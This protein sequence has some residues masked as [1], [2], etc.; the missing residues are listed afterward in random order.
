MN[1]Y[2][3]AWTIPDFA[4]IVETLPEMSPDEERSSHCEHNLAITTFLPYNCYALGFFYWSIL[5]PPTTTDCCVK[6]P[7]APTAKKDF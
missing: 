3:M 7:Q 4:R 1:E 6:G 2:L 5:Y